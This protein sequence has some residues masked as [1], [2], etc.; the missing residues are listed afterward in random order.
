MNASLLLRSG[1]APEVMLLY[2]V[3]P[4]GRCILA[5]PAVTTST[6]GE[7][8][9]WEC[10][11]EANVHDLSNYLTPEDG[12]QCYL[13]HSP[14]GRALG[15]LFD[16]P[17]SVDTVVNL[18]WDAS[19]SIGELI[20]YLRRFES[21]QLGL[22][23]PFEGPVL[24]CYLVLAAEHGRYYVKQTEGTLAPFTMV[25][26]EASYGMIPDTS[27]SRGRCHTLAF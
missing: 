6:P 12:W 9:S 23:S 22:Q 3:H 27:E 2:R 8:Q 10:D 14:Y 26:G 24:P 11:Y 16:R 1:F 4:F 7:Y 15:D 19:E 18:G 5:H 21:A 13:G 20:P 25:E 17:G